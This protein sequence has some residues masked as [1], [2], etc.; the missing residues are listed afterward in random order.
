MFFVDCNSNFRFNG[1]TDYRV[2]E[3]VLTRQ[4]DE[5][6][7]S[8]LIVDRDLGVFIRDNYG[9]L[10]GFCP[11]NCM[12]IEDVLKFTLVDWHRKVVGKPSIKEKI[13]EI[14]D[15]DNLPYGPYFGY[16]KLVDAGLDLVVGPGCTVFGEHWNK[17]VYCR[18][19]EEILNRKVIRTR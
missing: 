8:G 11:D 9:A 19:Y 6:I 17:A 14:K 1:V 15:G 13:R 5:S 10:V 7:E 12:T 4:L 2:S 18:N 16:D 3:D